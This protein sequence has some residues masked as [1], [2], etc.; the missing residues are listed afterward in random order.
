MKRVLKS[1]LLI[2]LLLFQTSCVTKALWGDKQYKEKITQFLVGNDG[3]YVVFVGEQ[4]HYIFTDDSGALKTI[5][6]LN[7]KVFDIKTKDT[8]LRL[9]SNNE[10]K[11]EIVMF[12]VST[13]LTPEEMQLLRRADIRPDRNGDLLARIEVTGRRYAAKYL[14]QNLTQSGS[15]SQVI[16]INYRDSN[17]IKDA[18]KVAVTPIAVGVD[19]VLLIGKVVVKV[20]EL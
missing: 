19:A 1:L 9:N 20:F 8:Y 10:L 2:S 12:G 11:G 17:V 6:S 5:L 14:N 4:Y 13:G 16:T 3:R 7:K 18:G 15:T